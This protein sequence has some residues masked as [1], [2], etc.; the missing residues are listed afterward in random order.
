[1]NFADRLIASCREADSVSVVGLDPH[2]EMLPESFKRDLPDE[3][4]ERA[5]TVA[6]RVG[7]FCRGIIE[8]AADCAPAVKPQIAFYEQ[9][10]WRGMRLY[11]D[12]A[13]YA[14]EAGLLVIGDIKRG[15]IGS[16]ATAYANA[17]LAPDAKSPLRTAPF[18][19]DAVTVNAY[20]GADAV[21]PFKRAVEDAGKGMFILVRTSNPAAAELQLA[22]CGGRPLWNRVAD[23]AARLGAD[24][25]GACGYSSVG[26]VIGAT[27]PVSLKQARGVMPNAPFLIP[28]YGA[29]G[30]GAAELAPAFDKDGI[31]S[32]VNSSRGI[33]FAFRSE[34]W[35]SQ[36][37]E[38]GWKDAARAALLEM[39][40][41]LNRAR[42][43]GKA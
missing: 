9:L 8:V 22:D 7:E 40:A 43:A 29:Q 26:A 2:W 38:A 15:D 19:V 37:G 3:P 10:G 23:L 42:R 34:P 36:F 5:Q 11:A 35:K 25:I 16:T 33:L 17:H 13:R 30:G 27:D 31:G 14:K 6:D 12:L 32:V 18:E 20:M 41:E 24:S 4:E 21:M 1:M 28:G 39:N